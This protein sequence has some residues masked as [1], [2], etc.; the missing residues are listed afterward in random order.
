MT[1]IVIIN[2]IFTVLSVIVLLKTRLEYR[3]YESQYDLRYI[4]WKDGGRYRYSIF[5]WIG[6]IFFALIPILP[7]FLLGGLIGHLLNNYYDSETDYDEEKK[8]FI[9]TRKALKWNSL[10]K[11][12]KLR[13]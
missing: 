11:F 2:L 6:L 4:K 5:V 7:I 8:L 12:L 3:E 13:V 1:A 9:E 10:Y